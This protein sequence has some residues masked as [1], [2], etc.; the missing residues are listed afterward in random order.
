MTIAKVHLNFRLP[1]R[2]VKVIEDIAPL[3]KDSGL[4][5]PN[6][7]A[8]TRALEHIIQYYMESEDYLKKVKFIKQQQ[9]EIFLHLA[10]KEKEWR[11][12]QNK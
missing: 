1:K 9:W 8:M 5:D 12:S 7:G 3:F 6:Y 11:E 4:N 10:Q 2:L